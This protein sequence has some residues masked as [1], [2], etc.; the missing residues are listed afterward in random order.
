M[1]SL[2]VATRIRSSFSLIRPPLR[3]GVS[4]RPRSI[5]LFGALSQDFEILKKKLSDATDVVRSTTEMMD[6]PRARAM[7][8]DLEV[9]VSQENFWD[10]SGTAQVQLQELERHKAEILRVDTWNSAI[11][12]AGAALEM[13]STDED[14]GAEFVAEAS[15]LMDAVAREVEAWR[16]EALLSGPFDGY[17]ARVVITAGAGGTD[18]QDWAQMLQRMYSRWG[19]RRGFRVDTVE[20]N[21][22]DEGCGIR[23]CEL[24][25]SGAR[26]YGL[27][28]GEKGTHRLVRI[29]PFNSL[30]KRQTSFAGVETTPIL[31]E[32]SLDKV[33]EVPE[34]DLQV[35]FMR[36]GGAGGQ[37][38]NKVRKLASLWNVRKRV[39]DFTSGASCV[40]GRDRGAPATPPDWHYGQVHA[41]AQPIS[42]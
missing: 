33:P 20:V 38:V 28:A 41:G 16:L 25:V 1:A 31:P 36:S 17:D 14:G 34:S 13:A 18:A 4:L 27:L 19:E 37:N 12:D 42:K 15:A 29:S 9:V 3:C 21:S 8:A 6:L 10:D 40:S 24:A 30:G 7:I 32:A 2:L 26:A 11:D 5:R 23:S 22:A 35:S 39:L